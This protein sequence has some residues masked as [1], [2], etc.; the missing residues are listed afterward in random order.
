VFSELTC[1]E[2]EILDLVESGDEA[3]S[4]VRVIGSPLLLE[5]MKHLRLV[6]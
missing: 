3:F 6:L 1:E 2:S 4:V 5:A